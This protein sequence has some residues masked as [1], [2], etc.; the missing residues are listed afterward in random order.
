M[1]RRSNPWLLRKIHDILA[2]SLPV[3][4]NSVERRQDSQQPGLRLPSVATDV[5]DDIHIDIPRDKPTGY[6]TGSGWLHLFLSDSEKHLG[7]LMSGNDCFNLLSLSKSKSCTCFPP[8]TTTQQQVTVTL[9]A[10][11]HDT[12]VEGDAQLRTASVGPGRGVGGL[13]GGQAGLPDPLP[14]RC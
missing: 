7:I 5:M 10:A 6:H 3:A 2:L 14:G 4:A 11:A 1:V 9:F 8:I 13:G 12:P